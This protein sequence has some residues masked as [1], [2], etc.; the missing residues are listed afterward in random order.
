MPKS[1]ILVSSDHSTFSQAFSESFRCSLANFRRV[2]TCDFLSRGTLRALQDFSPL[3]RSVLPM[4]CLVTM[5]P[6]AL[7]SLTRSSRVLLGWS[8]TFSHDHPHPKRWELAWSSRPRTIDGYFVFLPFLNNR[9]NC[10]LLLT[11]LLA[12]GLVAHSSLVQIYNLVPDVLW[13]L[14]GLAHGSAEVGMEDTDSMDRC[15]LYTQWPHSWNTSRTNLCV[16]RS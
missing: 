4:V 1:S 3:Q 16:I 10:C 12:D 11:K 14:F 6:A 15:L 7:R 9:T 8:L 2:C 13:Q 5:V